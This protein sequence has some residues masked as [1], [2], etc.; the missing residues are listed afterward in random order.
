LCVKIQLG[1]FTK[2]NAIQLYHGR[3]RGTNTYQQQ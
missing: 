1:K 3:R 2:Q